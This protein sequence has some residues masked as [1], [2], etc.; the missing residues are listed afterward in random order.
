MVPALSPS[1]SSRST[2]QSSA[3]ADPVLSLLQ[4][5][6]GRSPLASHEHEKD[7]TATSSFPSSSPSQATGQSSA[8][9]DLVRS[10]LRDIG[11]VPL[12]SHEQEITLGRQVQDLMHLEALE[13]QLK[14]DTGVAP[15][16]RSGQRRRS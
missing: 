9:A 14:Q 16:G 5:H 3:K 12:L 4:N 15:P 7:M 8:D 13:A 2:S 1:C 10:Y 6:V 11:R